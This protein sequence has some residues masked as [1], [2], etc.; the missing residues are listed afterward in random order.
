MANEH[1]D[2]SP[3]SAGRWMK[4]AGSV[5][6]SQGIEDKGS[7]Y[8]LEGT[9]AHDVAAMCL[10][11]GTDAA[12][13]VGRLIDAKGTEVPVTEDMAEN[14]QVYVDAVR[15]RVKAYELSGAQVTLEVEQRVPIG[16][17]TR[18]EGAEGTS[19]AV[20][21]AEFPDSLA[22]EVWDLKMGRGVEVQA[23]DNEQGQLY[24]LGVLK[25][26]GIAFDFDPTTPVGIVISQPRIAR[27]PSEW[28][29]SV[30][31][32][33]EF[34]R[35][36]TQ[37][38]HLIK[39]AFHCK[40]GGGAEF[41]E[42]Y[43]VP[44]A[45]CKEKFCKARGTCPAYRDSALSVFNKG[46]APSADEFED[47]VDQAGPGDADPVQWWRLL[48]SKAEQIEDLIAQS[49]ASAFAWVKDQGNAPE[50]IER[51]GFKLIE[52]KQGDRKWEDEEEAEKTLKS[53]RLKRDEMYEFKLITPTKAE[54]LAP[55][56]G[57]DGKVLPL[58][59]GKPEPRIGDRQWKKLQGL[60]TRAP[61]KPNL[62]PADHKKPPLVIKPVAD[63]FEDL[64]QAEPVTE[65]EGGG[66]C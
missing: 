30:Q 31:A 39:A 32:L 11:S 18:E 4:C 65:D 45:H 55:S 27:T 50:A 12:A 61:A 53:M 3:S 24:A 19:D 40:E 46:N 35:T 22:L 42:K 44:G 28:L 59:E 20:I 49:Y 54:A 16:H 21:I 62:V 60:I 47:L 2:L 36:C 14:V 57:K 15:E 48:L 9:A 17:I 23:A 63:E 7:E 51:L 5:V 6:L 25:K 58:K 29:T 52:G 13:Y 8:A 64:T 33:T 37:A 38:T 10:T 43:L 41:A 56:Y 26:F 1:A 34:G 66:L